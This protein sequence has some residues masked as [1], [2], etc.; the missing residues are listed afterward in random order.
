MPDGSPPSCRTSPSDF[1]TEGPFDRRFRRAA[2][3]D[4]DQPHPG[5]HRQQHRPRALRTDVR[6]PLPAR[7]RPRR[8][9][10]RDPGLR[11]AANCCRACA[12]ST[13][14]PR[15]E[16]RVHRRHPRP[17]R[18]RFR[19]A[20]HRA[21]GARRKRAAEGRLRHRR[22]VLPGGRHPHHHLR[23]R[24]HR[25]GAQGRRIRPPRPSSP[26]AKLS[27]TAWSMRLGSKARGSAPGFS[28]SHADR[29][30]SRG[31]RR[32][33]ASGSSARME[34]LLCSKMRRSEPG[35]RRWSLLGEFRRADPVMPPGEDER[36]RGDAAEFRAQIVALQEAARREGAVERVR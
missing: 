24:Q 35:I 1:R 7:Q 4:L 8:A 16:L 26:A 19:A 2:Q 30:R 14:T 5:R 29:R 17:R 13:R 9:D 32:S 3:H 22:L 33:R 18:D 6:A 27:S 11:R 20:A 15:I 36:R 21:A 28:A 23:P 25:T 12:R 10:P 34:W 31:S